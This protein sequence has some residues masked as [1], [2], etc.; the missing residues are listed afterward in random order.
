MKLTINLNE[1]NYG[2]VAVKMMPLLGKEEMYFSEA[3]GKTLNAIAA[4]PENLIR[5]IFE[6]I[7]AEQKNE[8]VVALAK[9]YKDGIM[10]AVNDIS[11]KNEIGVTL[12]DIAVN[13][14]NTIIAEVS[15]IDYRCL[16]NRFLP[17]IREKLMEMG[18]M[19]MLMLRPVIQNASADQVMGLLDRFV[20]DQDTFFASL[21][22]NNQLKLIQSIEDAAEKQNIHI[23]I[24][25]IVVEV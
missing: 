14:E 11:K 5:E 25:S 4:L 22:N 10:R 21:I 15:Q 19:A 8:I 12:A 18:G 6:V 24:S 2:D 3:V 20:S 7:P 16:I 9:E 13:Q 17:H 23:K 1:I